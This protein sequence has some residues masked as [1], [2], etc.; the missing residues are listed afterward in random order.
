MEINIYQYRR[1][2]TIGVC[3]I[4][5]VVLSFFSYTES[6]SMMGIVSWST[7]ITLFVVYIFNKFLW[8]KIP[9]WL[10]GRP[11][12]NGT[13]KGTL[14]YW[15]S[16]DSK[17][18]DKDKKGKV[19]P[20]FLIIKQTF[21][22]TKIYIFTAESKSHS[23]CSEIMLTEAETWKITYNYDNAPSLKLRDR[24]QRHRGAAELEIQKVDKSY[25]IKGEY[26]TDRWSQ[27]ELELIDHKAEHAT[28][29][30]AAVQMF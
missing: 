18:D 5:T 27:G 2:C 29:Y 16:P 20:F 30:D 19:D 1:K 24:S 17:D 28:N 13:W 8:K 14:T 26:W 7:N 3:A 11:N 4:I 23:L 21:L 12:L 25:Q 6:K 10:S 15:A 9:E 22:S